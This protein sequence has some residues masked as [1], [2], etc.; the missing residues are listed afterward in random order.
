MLSA[1]GSGAEGEL[2]GSAPSSF[3]HDCECDGLCPFKRL[4][5]PEGDSAGKFTLASSGDAQTALSLQK[6]FVKATIGWSSGK[7][8]SAI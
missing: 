7:E 8:D 6:D 4:R 5:V 2:S 1:P 3:G